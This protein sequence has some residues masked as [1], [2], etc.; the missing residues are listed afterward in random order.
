[1]RRKM[2]GGKVKVLLTSL[3][4]AVAALV[5]PVGLAQADDVR[6]QINADPHQP[7]SVAPP[8]PPALTCYTQPGYWSQVP[9]TST[10]GFIAYQSVW[11]PSQTVCR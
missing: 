8:P 4:I 2:I 1:M 9:Y 3:L 7:Y 10:A 11:V 5:V 6:I